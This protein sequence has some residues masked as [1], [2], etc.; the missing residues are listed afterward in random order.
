MTKNLPPLEFLISGLQH[1]QTPFLSPISSQVTSRC[2]ARL[3]QNNT[4]FYVFMTIIYYVGVRSQ[5]QNPLFRA[6]RAG[7][8]H[9]MCANHVRMFLAN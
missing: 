5:I 3:A 2:F 4:D 8:C 6:A 7:K 1:L 9:A